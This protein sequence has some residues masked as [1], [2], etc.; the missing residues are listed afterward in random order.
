MTHEDPQ[1]PRSCPIPPNQPASGRET[2][3]SPTA[4]V[5]A[6]L[7]N[8]HIL[9]SLWVRSPPKLRGKE[10]TGVVV[11]SRSRF[12]VW[13]ATILADRPMVVRICDLTRIFLGNLFRKL[14]ALTI[15]QIGEI[16]DKWPEWERGS[17]GRSRS[18]TE[19]AITCERHV[20]TAGAS[21]PIQT[22]GF[23]RR[24]GQNKY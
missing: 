14:S 16:A 6:T 8:D 7:T 15:M 19:A 9:S 11:R 22:T 10:I 13:V 23:G 1:Q 4:R 21:S 5:L 20:L 17:G 3:H 24:F 12:K 2:F 18:H